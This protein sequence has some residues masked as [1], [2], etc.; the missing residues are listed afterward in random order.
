VQ[1]LHD[2]VQKWKSLSHP[3]EESIWR[4]HHRVLDTE[5]QILPWETAGICRLY[6]G[7]HRSMNALDSRLS[8][9]RAF[10]LAVLCSAKVIDD[11]LWIYDRK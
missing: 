3:T 4:S 6:L 11:S 7:M 5:K 9:V 2:I 10:C 1:D 8:T